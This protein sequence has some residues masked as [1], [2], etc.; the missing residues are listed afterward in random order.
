MY[1]QNFINEEVLMHRNVLIQLGK[2]LGLNIHDLEDRDQV[3]TDAVVRLIKA[4]ASAGSRPKPASARRVAKALDN[5]G[6][7]TFVQFDAVVWS[8][9]AL[10]HKQW[11][12]AQ[13]DLIEPKLSDEQHVMAV[14]KARDAVDYSDPQQFADVEARVHRVMQVWLRTLL[15]HAIRD[16]DL[17]AADKTATPES[18]GYTGPYFS[19]GPFLAYAAAAARL[20]EEHWAIVVARP[21]EDGNYHERWAGKARDENISKDLH[22]DLGIV[23]RQLQAVLAQNEYTLITNDSGA[24]S[25]NGL[26]DTV[27]FKHRDHFGI[28]HSPTD[29]MAHY[30]AT[31]AKLP[32]SEREIWKRWRLVLR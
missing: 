2:R 31:D 12:L 15:G 21:W 11:E 26:P 16:E 10:L 4:S 29:A 24:R 17:T 3:L 6:V 28:G 23:P 5:S 30:L 19:E 32:E 27:L 14:A 1:D 18:I 13:L 25:R 8:L 9:Q 20:A 7:P 22:L